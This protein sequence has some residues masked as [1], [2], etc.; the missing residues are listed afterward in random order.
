MNYVAVMV[1]CASIGVVS[2]VGQTGFGKNNGQKLN[3]EQ[4]AVQISNH[5]T[6]KLGLDAAQS[7]R[8]RVINLSRLQAVE[9][10]RA[11]SEPKPDKRAKIQALQQSYETDMKSILSPAQYISFEKMKEDRMAKRK[12]KVKSA[13]LKANDV[14]DDDTE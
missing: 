4:R 12:N 10:L 5:L 8:V 11:S 3:P 14:A 1:L 9:T 2:A 6:K 13:Q 7:E